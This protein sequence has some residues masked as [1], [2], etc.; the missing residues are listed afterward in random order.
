MKELWAFIK[1]CR[2][3]FIR[4]NNEPIS[5]T[6]SCRDAKISRNPS[7]QKSRFNS[8][9]IQ[10][11][12]SDAGGRRFAVCAGNCQHWLLWNNDLPQPLRSRSVRAALIQNVFDQRIAAGQSITNYKQF[13]LVIQLLWMVSVLYRD[14]LRMQKIAHRRVDRLI[15][16]ADREACFPGN[17]RKPCHER[18]TDTCDV[19][20]G[21]QTD[22]L[23]LKVMMAAMI[24]DWQ[25]TM[26]SN[27]SPM[28]HSIACRRIEAITVSDQ[29]AIA[30]AMSNGV[31]N[32]ITGSGPSGSRRSCHPKKGSASSCNSVVAPNMAVRVCVERSERLRKRKSRLIRSANNS[33]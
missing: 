32:T 13:R 6:E 17:Q 29:I 4:L 7:D 18:P 27:A 10:N 33:T 14:I 22:G 20:R 12:G 31:V 23:P 21:F 24:T 26:I 3:V 30:A 11:K 9:L 16:A 8:A 1:E 19:D 15:T 28:P 5:G 25:A 2:I